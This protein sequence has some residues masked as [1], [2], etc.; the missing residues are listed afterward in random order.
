MLIQPI[1]S[2]IAILE[3]FHPVSEDRA[4]SVPRAVLIYRR[5]HRHPLIRTFGLTGGDHIQISPSYCDNSFVA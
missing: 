4:Q 3:T 2:S 5:P 1:P